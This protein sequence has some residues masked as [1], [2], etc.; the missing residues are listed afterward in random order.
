MKKRRKKK[1]KKREKKMMK[2]KCDE[3]DLI[4]RVDGHGLLLDLLEDVLRVQQ[5]LVQLVG[6]EVALAHHK[7]LGRGRTRRCGLQTQTSTDANNNNN[8]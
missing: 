8:K 6:L 4:E 3:A 1:K 2:K 5:L 7:D